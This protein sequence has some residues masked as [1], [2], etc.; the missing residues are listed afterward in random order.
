MTYTKQQLGRSA[1]QGHSNHVRYVCHKHHLIQLYQ[2]SKQNL[3]NY[4]PHACPVG[5]QVDGHKSPYENRLKYNNFELLFSL[6]TLH[7]FRRLNTDSLCSCPYSDP[8]YSNIVREER[9]VDRSE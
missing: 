1:T 8:D 9:E 3:Y 7:T 2:A 4:M 6:Y 5:N